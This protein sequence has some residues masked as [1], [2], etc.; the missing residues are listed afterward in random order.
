MPRPLAPTVVARLR[1]LDG[2][3][4]P[5][6]LLAVGARTA[7][8]ELLD[9]GGWHSFRRTSEADGDGFVIFAEYPQPTEPPPAA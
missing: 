6:V 4:L 1:R 2:G 7:F 3:T 8:L 9:D 5:G